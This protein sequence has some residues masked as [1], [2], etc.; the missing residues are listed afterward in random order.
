M[1]HTTPPRSRIQT[2]LFRQLFPIPAPRPGNRRRDNAPSQPSVAD[3]SED[4][5][6][7][8]RTQTDAD[9]PAKRARKESSS[10]DDGP[11]VRNQSTTNTRFSRRQISNAATG[12]RRETS[13]RSARGGGFQV[14]AN[15]NVEFV[16]LAGTGGT[17]GAGG[18]GGPHRRNWWEW[19]GYNFEYESCF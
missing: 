10:L 11:A 4:G 16:N 3:T 1:G 13:T 7:H 9:R 8:K 6:Q 18:F 12:F 2:S 14:N 15:Q 5:S 17:G 19:P